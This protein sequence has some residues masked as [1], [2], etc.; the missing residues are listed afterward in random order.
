MPPTILAVTTRGEFGLDVPLVAGNEIVVVGN[1][2]GVVKRL[3]VNPVTID[4]FDHGANIVAGTAAGDAVIRI[5]V[6]DESDGYGMLLRADEFGDWLAD[7]G[8]EGFV[9]NADMGGRVTAVDPDTDVMVAFIGLGPI[10][11]SMEIPF[12]LIQIGHSATLTATFADIEVP[13]QHTATVDWGD[14]TDCAGFPESCAGV[15]TYDDGPGSNGTA[16]ASHTYLETG[17]Y[18]VTV[19]VT[20]GRNAF[21]TAE[22]RYAVVYDPTGGFATGGGWIELGS[23]TA[24]PDDILPPGGSVGDKVR[25]GFSVKYRN[26]AEKPQGNLNAQIGDLHLQS[27]VFEW[28][29]ITVD[30]T[31]TAR[32]RGAA[33]IDGASHEFLVDAV[34]G[35]AS[36]EPDRFTIRL[37]P[38][39][40]D[41]YNDDPLYQVSGN[42][43]GGK[44]QIHRQGAT[45]K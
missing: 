42:L 10:V 27:E 17:V 43:S 2:T 33:T 29:V 15:V 41:I 12:D 35:D 4:V 22:Y 8:S 23:P 36:G 16:T 24:D 34:D 13:D 31:D 25:F 40:A 1:D 26:N 21:D 32:F 44:I 6:G 20:D 3:V 37:W 38:D 45:A 19:T 5:D 11:T 39:G 14:G 7:F 18:T 9:L 28:M 30:V